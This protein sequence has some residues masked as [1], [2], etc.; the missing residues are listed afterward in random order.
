MPAIRS[1]RGVSALLA[2]LLLACGL[3]G[4]TGVAVAPSAGALCARQPLEGDWRNIDAA[5]RAVTRVVVGFGCGDVRLCDETGICTG[6]QSAYTLRP[7]GRCSPAD[8]DWGV[9][10]ATPMADG[11]YRAVYPFGFKTSYVWVKS[12]QFYGLTYL[13]VYVVND[14]SPGDGRADYTT[15]EWMLR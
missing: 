2:I 12:Y 7:F 13:R 14:F 9:R 5:T 6:G 15:D 3:L 1:V 4:A 8:C 11:W 10:S